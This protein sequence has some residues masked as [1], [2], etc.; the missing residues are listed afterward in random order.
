MFAK[1]IEGNGGEYMLF[2]FVGSIYY[3]VLCSIGVFVFRFILRRLPGKELRI[4]FIA[5]SSIAMLAVHGI[6]GWFVMLVGTTL[7]VV[8]YRAE[9][10]NAN[11]ARALEQFDT[12]GA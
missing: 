1:E 9:V 11:N 8:T 3:L 4:G 5:V 7:T 2:V 10:K 6:P 12:H